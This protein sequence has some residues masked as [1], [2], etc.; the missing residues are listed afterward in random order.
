MRTVI[1]T[2]DRCGQ[3]PLP[4]AP[5]RQLS[6]SPDLLKELPDQAGVGARYSVELCKPCADKFVLFMKNR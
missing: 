1:V 2:C 6:L 3:N 4:E 5:V